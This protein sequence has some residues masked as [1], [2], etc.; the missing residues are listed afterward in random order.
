MIKFKHF[1]FYFTMLKFLFFSFP[2]NKNYYKIFLNE[3]NLQSDCLFL[4]GKKHYNINIK[5]LKVNYSL[6]FIFQS[7]LS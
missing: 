4:I 2:F 3:L 6:N 5:Q 1:I 7:F